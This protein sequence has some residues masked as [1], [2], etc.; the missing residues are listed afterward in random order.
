MAGRVFKTIGLLVG[1]LAG[2]L[3]YLV[4]QFPLW[5]FG[6]LLS[7]S[8]LAYPIFRHS[9]FGVLFL[10][11]AGLALG[12]G[13]ARLA[14]HL[15][16]P[17]RIDYY[18]GQ[19]VQFEGVVSEVD[20][21]REQ[22][23]YTISVGAPIG[24]P[25]EAPM[26]ENTNTNS[27]GSPNQT[28]IGAP[29]GDS[30][31][32]LIGLKGDVLITLDKY[33][34][35]LTGD[36]IRLYGKLEAP[37]EFDGFSYDH[38][39]SRFGIYSVMYRP[40][41]TLVRSGEGSLFWRLMAFSRDGFLNRINRL[42]PEPQASFMAGLLVGARKG[43]PPDL[44]ERFNTTG[45]SHIVAISGFNITIILAFVLWALKGLPRK[46]GFW[47]AIGAVDLFTLFVGASPSVTR[48]AIMGILGLMALHHGR[49][50]NL[51]LTVLYTAF[52]MT[53]WNPKIL[54][55]DVGFQ[56]S[57]AAVLGLIY[58]SPLFKHWLERLP[59]A[60]GIR[61]AIQMTLSAQVM[62]FPIIAFHFGRFSLIAPLANLLV[63]FAIP[64]AMLLGFL[65]IVG[66][67]F[68]SSLGL[69]LAYVASGVLSYILKVVDVLA[70]V[71]FAS[72]A[73]PTLGVWF[74]FGYYTLLILGLVLIFL[75]RS[76]QQSQTMKMVKDTIY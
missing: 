36:R 64:P 4:I 8:I 50:S 39:L 37:G 31:G 35:F 23:K 63:A 14:E 7:G 6:L 54:W 24:A 61:E 62:A 28:S 45:L 74:V 16:T 71:P 55:W 76:K 30:T 40:K 2:V 3:G 75:K 26:G 73:M 18:N 12:F 19:T 29:I 11:I 9:K 68:L 46:T 22:A 34:Q 27:N 57:F 17:D 42:F 70:E 59:E 1:F 10:L 53:L 25:V 44:T 66:S 56:L 51:H 60:F 20:V 67:L 33:P 48:S 32:A 72:L 43:I 21:R 47:V 58:V 49:Q 38:Y 41:A 69:G 52:F 5:V 15:T 65:A 13:R